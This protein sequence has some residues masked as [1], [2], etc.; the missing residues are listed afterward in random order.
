MSGRNLG[1]NLVEMLNSHALQ[2]AVIFALC[3]HFLLTFPF[4]C[5]I[6][7][8]F[9]YK[10]SRLLH[11]LCCQPLLGSSD[12]SRP[13]S[14]AN[15]R[16]EF[17]FRRSCLGSRVQSNRPCTCRRLGQE[18]GITL[19]EPLP[20][21]RPVA[22]QRSTLPKA[23]CVLDLFVHTQAFSSSTLFLPSRRPLNSETSSTSNFPECQTVDLN[24]WELTSSSSSIFR[25]SLQDF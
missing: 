2:V 1:S 13:S 3:L 23:G 25:G 18:Q 11:K 16:S 8:M 9:A 14:A 7:H 6:V 19:T 10:Q 4:S 12:V 15:S 21:K 24:F 20:V 5:L 17:S 22:R